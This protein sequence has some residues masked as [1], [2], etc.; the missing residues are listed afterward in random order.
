[1]ILDGVLYT[2]HYTLFTERNYGATDSYFVKFIYMYF[3]YM[4][5]LSATCAALGRRIGLESTDDLLKKNTL[6]H[7]SCEA[8]YA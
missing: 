8:E 1:M 6:T 7:F 3:S 5:S 2:L 4:Q